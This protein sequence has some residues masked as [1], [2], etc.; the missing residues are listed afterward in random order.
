MSFLTIITV[1]KD[2]QSGFLQT[3]Q[4]INQQSYCKQ[5]EWIIVDSS[6]D[7]YVTPLCNQLTE[8]TPLIV[9]FDERGI[10][11]AMNFGAKLVKT[12]YLMFLNGGDAF[13][14][15]NVLLNLT[16][17]IYRSESLDIYA[18]NAIITYSSKYRKVCPPASVNEA[19]RGFLRY[20]LPFCHQAVIYS[21]N[22]FLEYQ[23][24]HTTLSADFH[25]LLSIFV[26]RPKYLPLDLDIV[27]YDAYGVSNRKRL[28]T[29]AE[30]YAAVSSIL[31][32]TPRRFMF[33]IYRS[34]REA[35]VL[36][37]NLQ[38]Q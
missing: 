4:S 9:K 31:G 24:Y 37:F 15:E 11:P 7:D 17:A 12:D 5:I 21:K 27:R 23:G 8:L 13:C 20:Q 22:I 14:N 38:S 29:L 16:Q 26:Q 19:L 33:F 6:S 30:S 25:Q 10:Y 28:V 35:A 3:F 36:F 34:L 2:D 32:I 18:G 1:T